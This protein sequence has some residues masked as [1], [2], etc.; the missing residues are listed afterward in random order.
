M[1][2]MKSGLVPSMV[3]RRSGLAL[4]S[5]RVSSVRWEVT[6]AWAK[7]PGLVLRG[8]ISTLRGGTSRKDQSFRIDLIVEGGRISSCQAGV[9]MYSF[10]TLRSCIRMYAGERRE[11]DKSQEIGS[12]LLKAKQACVRSVRKRRKF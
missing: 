1:A 10:I 3:R 11:S 5:G 9:R 4:A 12:L 7:S 6:E 2:E 8:P